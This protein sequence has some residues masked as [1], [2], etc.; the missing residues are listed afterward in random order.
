MHPIR[1][2]IIG[3]LASGHPLTAQKMLGQLP[4]VPVA[5]LYR[6]LNKLV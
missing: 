3:L 6:H 4:D 5:T 2:R 1:L